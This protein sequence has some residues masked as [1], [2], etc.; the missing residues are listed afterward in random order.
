VAVCSM[1][2]TQASWHTAHNTMHTAHMYWQVRSKS[3]AHTQPVPCKSL[4]KTVL[5]SCLVSASDCVSGP[6][7]FCSGL[8]ACSVGLSCTAQCLG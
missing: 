3:L 6:L 4:C 8:R 2:A 7:L 1:Q 5:P